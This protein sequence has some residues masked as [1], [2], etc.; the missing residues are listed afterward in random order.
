MLPEYDPSFLSS[1]SNP[2]RDS[3]S[4]DIHLR[5][6]PQLRQDQSYL[7]DMSD[8]RNS[9]HH[10]NNNP[11][12]PMVNLNETYIN[13]PEAPTH[14]MKKTPMRAQR[15]FTHL[16]QDATLLDDITH[17]TDSGP[18]DQNTPD[19]RSSKNSQEIVANATHEM[20]IELKNDTYKALIEKNQMLKAKV[21]ATQSLNAMLLDKLTT[22]SVSQAVKTE[23]TS[24]THPPIPN[25]LAVD[26]TKI[27]DI[28]PEQYTS[29]EKET[30][31]WDKSN[32][33]AY[34]SVLLSNATHKSG[35]KAH[36]QEDSTS[37]GFI[38]ITLH[39]EGV[40]P[41]TWT[42][43][44]SIA[45][46]YF[47]FTMLTRYPEFGLCVDGWKLHQI[48]IKEYKVSYASIQHVPG[49]TSHTHIKKCK[50]H[51]ITPESATKASMSKRNK[52][53]HVKPES[54]PLSDALSC[55]QI[56]SRIHG[57][58]HKP[59]VKPVTSALLPQPFTSIPTPQISSGDNNARE[60]P[61]TNLKAV[62]VLAAMDSS[63][64]PAL[65][66]V[67]TPVVSPL[68][69]ESAVDPA[70]LSLPATHSVCDNAPSTQVAAPHNPMPGESSLIQTTPPVPANSLILMGLD[71]LVA[72][73]SIHM[74]Q[75]TTAAL[76]KPAVTTPHITPELML[77]SPI[78]QPAP[79]TT[80]QPPDHDPSPAEPPRSTIKLPAVLNMFGLEFI[81]THP[82][83]TK[84]EVKSAWEELTTKIQATYK[85]K[86]TNKKEQGLLT[87]DPEPETISKGN[88]AAM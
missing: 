58:G 25:H 4:P 43:A 81:R 6:Y 62:D 46:D 60:N 5:P 35:H 59:T 78:I 36:D 51:D 85:L 17:T 74:A 84:G 61:I 31:F 21:K 14:R 19:P 9:K 8:G 66:N 34:R 55:Q 42:H 68:P 3:I 41:Q 70:Q 18:H 22:A 15:P 1:L 88:A 82:N 69:L 24:S 75:A 40:A 11:I 29:E 63:P 13:I 80:S 16:N 39:D 57:N 47:H 52:P 53:T 33:T 79:H 86:G 44:S 83:T 54:D 71:Y 23:I 65:N 45:N 2:S 30:M 32:W 38:F 26:L 87:Q 37:L 67:F 49:P 56:M 7:F 76:F 50:Y 73:A 72:T 77:K 28:D 10:H 12:L 20:L 27:T 64:V 48:A